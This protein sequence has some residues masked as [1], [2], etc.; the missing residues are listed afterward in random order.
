MAM[1]SERLD[2]TLIDGFNRSAL[3]GLAAG[4]V[5]DGQLVYAR[6]FGLADAGRKIP[7]A[8]VQ[9]KQMDTVQLMFETAERIGK[10]R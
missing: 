7:A 1:D 2:R 10:P 5:K 3:A 6:A 4:I 8:K 9:A